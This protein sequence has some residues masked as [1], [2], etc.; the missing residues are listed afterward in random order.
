MD[1][2]ADEFTR[3]PEWT[4]ERLVD[5]SKLTGL[6]EAQIYKWGWDQRRK[7]IAEGGVVS[8]NFG[9]FSADQGDQYGGDMRDSPL[10]G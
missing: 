1:L 3:D 7:I 5:L 8:A 10:E 2:L 6:S 4:K 9:G